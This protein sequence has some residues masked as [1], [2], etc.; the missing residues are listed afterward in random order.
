M[1]V[2]AKTIPYMVAGR[3][4]WFSRGPQRQDRAFM[5][6]I[7]DKV[8][9]IRS[10]AQ[11]L[12]LVP[13]RELARQVAA[14]AEMLSGDTAFGSCRSMAAWVTGLRWMVPQGGAHRRGNS[15][16]RARPSA[17]EEPDAG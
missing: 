4:L 6:P 8:N 2:Q 12:I 1:P 15:G 17:A 13:T 10:P 7:L 11:A 9:R 3:M 16:P 14:E 5:L